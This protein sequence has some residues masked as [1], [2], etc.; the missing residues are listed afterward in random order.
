VTTRKTL[1]LF[2]NVRPARAL[3]PFV[4]TKHPGMDLVIIRENEED[5]YAGI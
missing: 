3:D 2:A 5:L 1:G 4:R